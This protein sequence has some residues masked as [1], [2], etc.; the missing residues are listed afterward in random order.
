MRGAY[1]PRD[2]RDVFSLAFEI[3][4]EDI[5]ANGHVNNVVYVRWIQDAGVSHWNARF[6]E[7]D[8]Q[9]WSWVAL[10]HEIDYR[11][12]LKL[13][14]TVQGV[15]WVG[16]PD[17]ARFPR[18]VRIEG[19]DGLAAQGRTDWCLVDAASMRPARIPPD[20]LAPFTRMGAGV[21]R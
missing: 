20:M 15:T 14:D 1:E 2:D 6:P 9:R 3:A 4:P 7:S 17:G 5:D 18:F 16:D 10:R 11:R 19:P 21:G 12:A 8:R 13:G